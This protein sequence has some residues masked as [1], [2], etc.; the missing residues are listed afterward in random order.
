MSPR[1]L[2]RV[3]TSLQSHSHPCSLEL[4]FDESEDVCDQGN[5]R[6]KFLDSDR[7]FAHI[8]SGKKNDENFMKNIMTL[9]LAV[10]RGNLKV[11]NDIYS[12]N[13]ITK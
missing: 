6:P 12:I 2:P 1:D 10:Y 13:T 4:G 7:L 11:M 8:V 5:E 9:C 3:L